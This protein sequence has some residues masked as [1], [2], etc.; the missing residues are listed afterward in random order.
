M[1]GYTDILNTWATRI[2]R[3]GVTAT[4]PL[5]LSNSVRLAEGKLNIAIVM[6]EPCNSHATKDYETMLADSP[7][8]SEVDRL[9]RDCCPGCS[10]NGQG[11]EAAL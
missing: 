9:I 1:S 11:P 8:L 6:I 3:S 10:C 5:A 4:T 2:N 7:S